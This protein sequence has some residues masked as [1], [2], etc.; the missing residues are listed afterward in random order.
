MN[1][2]NLGKWLLLGVKWMEIDS[3]LFS[4]KLFTWSLTS[5]SRNS[6]CP[7]ITPLKF[8]SLPLKSYRAPKGKNRLPTIPFQGRAVK[9]CGCMS[10]NE[11]CFILLMVQKSQTTTWDATGF[12]LP[13]SFNRWAPDFWTINST[14]WYNAPAFRSFVP[15][16]ITWKR[17]LRRG[18]EYQTSPIGSMYGIFTYIWLK[19]MVN[20]G[21]HTIHESYGSFTYPKFNSS[22]LKSGWLEDAAF[23]LGRALF[24]RKLLNFQGEN[25]C[26]GK[27][28]HFSCVDLESSKIETI[29]KNWCFRFE[30]TVSITDCKICVTHLI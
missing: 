23:L 24:R 10:K 8:S 16:R 30:V 3:N 26:L 14:S 21:K 29:V 22:P 11:T 1:L 17:P 2:E 4:R 13:T 9:L 20:V 28:S 27:R 5:L 15:K 7:K 6:W 25:R 19:F 18:C 12:Q